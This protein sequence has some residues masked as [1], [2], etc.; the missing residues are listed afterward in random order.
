[1]AFVMRPTIIRFPANVEHNTHLRWEP[2]HIS[3]SA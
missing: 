1:L 3:A 2:V